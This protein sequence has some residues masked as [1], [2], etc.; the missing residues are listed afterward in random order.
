[1]FDHILDW[2]EVGFCLNAKTGAFVVP[3]LIFSAK[4]IRRHSE[5]DDSNNDLLNKRGNA[6]Q[7]EPIAQNADD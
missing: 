1:M 3:E 7:V 4:G 5:C 2:V 6:A